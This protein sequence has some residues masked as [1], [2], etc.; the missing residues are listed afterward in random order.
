[1]L[2]PAV[3]QQELS[4]TERAL[5]QQVPVLRGD[6]SR[7]GHPAVGATQQ[8]GAERE[9]EL[10]HQLLS[11]QGGCQLGATEQHQPLDAQLLQRF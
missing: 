1:M 2:N 7:K 5:L 4:I 11:Q 3:A 8:N 10:I 6:R 9:L